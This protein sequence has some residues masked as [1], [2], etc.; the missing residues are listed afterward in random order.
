M[1]TSSFA[2]I[3]K[4]IF[5][6]WS[7]CY[8]LFA[9]TN[10]WSPLKFK[11][12]TILAVKWYFLVSEQKY[13]ALSIHQQGCCNEAVI[14]SLLTGHVTDVLQTS[15]IDGIIFWQN[16]RQRVV[17]RDGVTAWTYTFVSQLGLQFDCPS[18]VHVSSS[19][20]H[21][22]HSVVE[23]VKILQSGWWRVERNCRKVQ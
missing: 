11:L 17:G 8:D 9:W 3:Q 23:P 15:G 22:F 18:M 12:T 6:C 1:K 2:N 13:K 20:F 10:W 14:V 21:V 16:D 19:T 7:Y 5:S 4:V